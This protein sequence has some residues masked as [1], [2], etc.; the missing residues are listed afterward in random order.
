MSLRLFVI[1]YPV[2]AR[3]D[4]FAMRCQSVSACLCLAFDGQTPVIANTPLH[5]TLYFHL[6]VACARAE[7]ISSQTSIV[8]WPALP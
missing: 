4:V 7:A 2:C 6:T 8:I 5:E 3:S 1:L